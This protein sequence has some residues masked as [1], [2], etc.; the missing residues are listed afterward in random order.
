MTYLIFAVNPPTTKT[1]KE[2]STHSNTD[3]DQVENTVRAVRAFSAERRSVHKVGFP[4]SFERERKQVQLW[5]VRD[6]VF[7]IG[8]RRAIPLQA[9]QK[10]RN[11]KT[12][13]QHKSFCAAIESA[14]LLYIIMTYTVCI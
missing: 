6:I 11:S 4:L 14:E 12:S 7:A 10:V 13:L 9:T 1:V 2:I 8:K 3:L 5:N